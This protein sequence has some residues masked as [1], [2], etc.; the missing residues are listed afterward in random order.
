MCLHIYVHMCVHVI[1]CCSKLSLS[2]IGLALCPS[3][4]QD[5]GHFTISDQQLGRLTQGTTVHIR[6]NRGYSPIDDVTDVTCSSD[7]TWFPNI[8][9]CA[10]TCVQ[11]LYTLYSGC[12]CGWPECDSYMYVCMF[13]GHTCTNIQSGTI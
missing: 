3:F 11:K 4:S 7:G 6:C 9:K 10:G 8:P 1:V 12:D 5:N 13:K 2:P